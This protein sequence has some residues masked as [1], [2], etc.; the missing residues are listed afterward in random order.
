MSRPALLAAL[1]PSLASAPVGLVPGAAPGQVSTLTSAPRPAVRAS[2]ARAPEAAAL[3]RKLQAAITAANEDPDVAAAQLRTT[4]DEVSA[5]PGVTARSQSL[6]TLRIEGLLTLA[7]AT[8]VLEERDA[9]VEAID[10]AIR[11]SGGNVPSVEDFGPSLTALYEERVAAPQLRAVG[12][13][14]VSCTSP[15][16]VILDGRVAGTGNNV[17]V[18]GIPLGSHVARLEPQ[19]QDPTDFVMKDFVLTDDARSQEYSYEPPVEAT[20]PGGTAAT[21][22]TQ[23]GVESGRTLPRWAGILG[24]AAG[25]AALLGGVFALA[26]NGRCPD[27]SDANREPRCRDVFET[28]PVGIGLTAAGAGALVGFGVAFG[29][30]EG[31]DKRAR[32]QQG[33]TAILQFGMRF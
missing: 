25:G 28:L 8:L 12:S 19:T 11:V 16:R 29:I 14:Q 30:G 9:A 21:T 18:T 32:Q 10:E 3:E 6:Q 4:L 20:P 5:A 27:L 23:T 7:R 31:K 17:S 24:M 22:T 15:C 1:V 2:M 13:L 33:Q 26:I